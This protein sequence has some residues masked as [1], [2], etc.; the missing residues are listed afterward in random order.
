M[1]GVRQQNRERIE[2]ELMAA[3][4]R[5]LSTVGAAG[6]S[7]REIARELDMVSSAIYRYV[8]S[9][10]ELLTRLITESYEHL[11][12]V[13]SAADNPASGDADRWCAVALAVR[14]W[15]LDHPHDYFLLYG[16]PVPGYA[17][18]DA[19]IEPGTRVV[20][21]L[22]GIMVDAGKTGRLGPIDDDVRATFDSTTTLAREIEA[23]AAEWTPG[24]RADPE[25]FIAFVGAW[26]QLFGMISFELTNQTR[27]LTNDSTGLFAATIRAHAHAVGLR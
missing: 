15:A 19:T 7:L 22:L 11:G 13:A 25:L 17:A 21:V 20:R 4:R 2:R 5:Q 26:S 9:R 12:A 23:I 8:E 1:A 6:I 10:D 27:G 16:S 14:Q 18:P 3:A 24:L